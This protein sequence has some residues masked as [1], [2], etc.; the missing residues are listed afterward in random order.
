M[1]VRSVLGLVLACALLA[2]LA[3]ASSAEGFGIERYGLA[4][5][6]EGGSADTQAGS[7]PYE[8]TAEVTVDHAGGEVKELDFELPPGLSFKPDAATQCTRGELV[9][10]D[11]PDGAAVGVVAMNLAG[12]MTPAAVYDMVPVPGEPAELGFMIDG[13][14][15]LVDM[16]VRTGGDYGPT[17]SMRDIPEREVGA[18]RLT[19]WGVPGEPSHDAQRG[20]CLTDGETDCGGAEPGIPFLT[21]PSAC[22]AAFQ[23][24]ARGYSWKE[25]AVSASDTTVFRQLRG[26]GLQS[27]K[28]A[29]DV[30]PDTSYADAPTGYTVELRVPLSNDPSSPTAQ[31][32]NAQIAL[33]MGTSLNPAAMEVLVGC[34]EAQSALTSIEEKAKGEENTA[35]PSCP[36][37]ARVGEVKIDS[38]L[39]ETAAAK[40]FVG[41]VYVLQSNPPDVKLLLAASADGVNLKL[42]ANARLNE[43]TGQITLS[44]DE[45]PQ[46]AI[47][48]IQLRFSGGALALLANPQTCGVF[49]A[50][51][52]LA[53]WSG[54]PDAAPSS[55]FAT[56]AEAEGGACVSPPPFEPSLSA[57]TL[58]DTAGSFSPLI[59]TVSTHAPEQSL[60]RLS[61]GLP[62]G[63]EWMFASVPPCG[64]PQ[65]ADGACTPASE[66]GTATVEAGPGP[67]PAS[68]VGAVYL[69]EGYA[70]GQYG[71]SIAL[72]MPGP[73]AFP[74]TI[75][76]AALDVS[77]ATGAV[78][79]AGDPLPQI[80]DGIPLRI[81]TVNITIERH[82][83][84]QNPTICELRQITA[85]I[86][87]A[88]G[89]TAQRSNPFG[90]LGCQSPATGTEGAGSPI[91][92]AKL[93]LS[94]ATIA[95]RRGGIA[96]V[97]L[98]CAGAGTC[99]GKLTL[100]VTNTSTDGRG[101]RIA[102]HAKSGEHAKNS[103]SRRT[104]I[105]T[106][107]FSIPA[108][109][110]AI[111]TLRLDAAG[112][113]LLK[114]HHGRLSASLTIVESSGGSTSTRY[115]SV[116]LVLREG[117]GAHGRMQ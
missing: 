66:I 77:S 110:T 90:T 72:H 6:E 105:G 14:S 56:T 36:G 84:V 39:I 27:F 34:S 68:L 24:T 61:F 55:S 43:Q 76:R 47:S 67:Y 22:A 91:A 64:E 35:A 94:G 54:G 62:P 44:L 46:L 107:T 112:R 100:Q 97:E 25:P 80:V 49:T 2:T 95:V 102:A 31:L 20:S 5:T 73:F 29:I 53:P 38:A 96:A 59:L 78:S 88:Q 83:F 21:L 19:L 28:P 32:E 42:V 57:G 41:G 81:H 82:E 8:L 93:S 99:R 85:A 18:V 12:T 13:V 7:Q 70:G 45:L 9:E 117:H 71:L 17:A 103:R 63:L 69:T 98:M 23:T 1:T 48:D 113:A 3:G 116:H 74:E 75:L 37:A 11:C 111:V 60:S 15:V 79:I 58:I 51:S 92:A 115:E 40:E 87:G 52:D 109:R 101:H 33:P 26:C 86:E 89:T 114:A 10:G 16:V 65:A 50:T 4:A 106:G 108:G 30:E 104:T